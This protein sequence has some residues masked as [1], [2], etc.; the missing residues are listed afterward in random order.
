MDSMRSE[1]TGS[2]ILSEAE[3]EVSYLK[4][5]SLFPAVFGNLGK[6]M[7][8]FEMQAKLEKLEAHLLP[9]SVSRWYNLPSACFEKRNKLMADNIYKVTLNNQT[10]RIAVFVGAS[11]VPFLRRYL[12]KF[13]SLNILTLPDLED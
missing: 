10:K 7:N 3:S 9:D 4:W 6:K 1:M 8:S 11:H 5:G 13:P 2:Q 12:S